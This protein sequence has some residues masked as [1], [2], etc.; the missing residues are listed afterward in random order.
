[1][2]RPRI[3]LLDEPL[4]NLDAK[5]RDDMRIEIREIQKRLD[6]TTV[7]VTHDQVEALTMCDV[8]GV[9]DSGK[10]AQLGSPEEIYEK[11]SSLFVAKFVGRANV[12][13]CEIV[14]ENVC[15]LGSGTYRCN[16]HGKSRGSGQIAIRPHRINLTPNRDR[17]LVSVVTN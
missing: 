12:H 6:I 16:T 13:N 9:M 8:V 1:V 10:L 17:N 3:L 2:I 14:D 4:S 5:L 11:P 7:F 15:R